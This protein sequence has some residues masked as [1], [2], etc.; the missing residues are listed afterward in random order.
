MMHCSHFMKRWN[1]KLQ[2]EDPK[3]SLVKATCMD[4]PLAAVA[5]CVSLMKEEKQHSLGS[6]EVK[7]NQRFTQYIHKLTYY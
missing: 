7:K 2:G 1:C 6:L 4:K 3:V 5:V